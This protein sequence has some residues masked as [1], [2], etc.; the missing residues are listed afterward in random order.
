MIS[1][2]HDGGLISPDEKTRLLDVIQTG[3][4]MLDRKPI[5]ESLV[6]H[7]LKDEFYKLKIEATSLNKNSTSTYFEK[8]KKSF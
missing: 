2:A 3:N 6:E 8:L 5:C 7:K 1:K 4:N